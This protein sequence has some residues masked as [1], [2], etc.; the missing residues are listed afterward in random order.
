MADPTQGSPGGFRQVAEEELLRLHRVTVV[1]ARFAAPDGTEFERDVIRDRKVVAMV[2][3]LD[4]G[5][6]VL[7][8]RQYRGPLD[9]WMVEIPAGLCDVEGEDDPEVT[10]RRELVEEVGR[11]AG[12]LELLARMHP[13]GGL[14]DCFE[15]LYLATDLRE[16]PS[17]RQGPEEEHM[18]VETLS[19]RD[20]P[21]LVSDGVLTDAK[22]VV[23]LLMARE[24]LG[25]R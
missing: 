22:T 23:G 10:A 19:L 11:E 25:V 2:P 15:H 8:V 14:T 4:D 16:V 3:L 12:R 17:D 20:V 7:V 6:T 5:E 24:H 9:A 1:R 21:R 18:V 13:S